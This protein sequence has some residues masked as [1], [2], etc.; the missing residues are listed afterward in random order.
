MREIPAERHPEWSPVAHMPWWPALSAAIRQQGGLRLRHVP[1]PSV[2]IFRAP[3]AE[4]TFHP[5]PMRDTTAG[6]SSAELEVVE[7]KR[8]VIVSQQIPMQA[9]QMQAANAGFGA[10]GL[11]V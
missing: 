2:P 1:A 8:V 9:T 7:A 6:L 4:Q 3:A 10:A 11:S 5:T